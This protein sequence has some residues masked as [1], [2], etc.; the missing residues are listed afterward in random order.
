MIGTLYL[1]PTA[2]GETPWSTYLPTATRQIACQL[3]RFIV[4]N[5]K[6]ARA[7]LKRLEHPVP[8]RELFIE[9]IPENPAPS[10]IE[11]LLAPLL[12]GENVGLLSEAGCPCIADPGT[13]LVRRAHELNMT[14]RPLI[15][16][17]AI[18]LALM[19]AGLEGQQ[20]TFHGYLP[21][22]EPER[23]QKIVELEKESKHRNQTQLFIEAPYRNNALFQALLTACQ[24]KTRLCI[25]FDLTL[26]AET[27]TLH[28]INEWR[29]LP[30]PDIDRRPTVFL[31][32]SSLI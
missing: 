15:G 7:E 22:R 17:S 1:I 10:D 27:I 23:S 5:A 19:A 14:V 25:A 32:L 29:R 4:E 24:P 16:P 2:L 3:T 30:P 11:R 18:L 28:T 6:T 26:P 13:L 12:I 31:M 8:L 21:A 9:Q 20:F